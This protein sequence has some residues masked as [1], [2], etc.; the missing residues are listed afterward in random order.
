MS[1]DCIREFGFITEQAVEDEASLNTCVV[2]SKAWKFLESYAYSNKKEDRFIRAASFNGKKALQVKNFVGFITTPDGTYLEILPKI[3]EGDQSVEATRKLLIRMLSA[4]DD[5]NFIATTDADVEIFNKP[6]AEVLIS[7]FLKELAQVVRK[8]IR[9]DYVNIEKEERFLKGR[10]LV[11]QQVKQ[12]T[13]KQHL[14]RIAYDFFSDNRA[15]NRLI[16]SALIQIA[17]WSKSEV[18]QRIARELRFAFNE[19]PVS[20]NYKT[21]LSQWSISRD[22]VGYKALLPWV[23]LILNQQSPFAVKGNQAGI[24]YLFPME[25]LFEKYVA[26]MLQKHATPP[27]KFETQKRGKY[28]SI[29]PEAFLLKPDLALYS[30]GNLVGILDTKWKLIDQDTKYGNGSSD[31]KS[32]IS[33]ADIYQMFAYGH[34]YLDGGTGRM[35]LI[36]PQW[37]KFNEDKKFVL[38]ESQDE[39]GLTLSVCPFNLYA[40]QKSSEAILN[41]LTQRY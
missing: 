41:K 15:E 32:G 40:P 33:Q 17:H 4:V 9:K 39:I 1:K 36:Y 29:A 37:M 3:S 21:D 8:G 18:N 28:L 31:I 27:Y 16:H 24:S 6:L 14:F 23:R 25:E 7:R 30:S 35:M 22:M 19:I 11:S 10:L 34:K 20:V 12:L 13:T 2:N 5:L 26:K 38:S